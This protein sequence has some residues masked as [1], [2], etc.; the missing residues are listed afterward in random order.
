M[1]DPNVIY[2]I[3]YFMCSRRGICESL[4]HAS[5]TH[6]RVEVGDSPILMAQRTVSIR[7]INCRSTYSARKIPNGSRQNN[8]YGLLLNLY[9]EP[10][11]PPITAVLTFPDQRISR[12]R[13]ENPTGPITCLTRNCGAKVP[14]QGLT[15]LCAMAFGAMA[16][17]SNVKAPIMMHFKQG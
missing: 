1:P 15:I 10:C 13:Q 12:L 9:H 7:T 14:D 2:M 4:L 5:C 17:V 6:I 11:F 8:Q 16:D 3:E